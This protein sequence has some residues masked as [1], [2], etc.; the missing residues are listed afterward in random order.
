MVDNFFS[1]MKAGAY[2][3]P[4]QLQFDFRF[5]RA[6]KEHLSTYSIYASV[7]S[8]KV[9]QGRCDCRSICA[10]LSVVGTNWECNAVD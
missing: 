2:D 10:T 4:M 7:M 9:G 8:D 3:M 6:M 1:E 5:S